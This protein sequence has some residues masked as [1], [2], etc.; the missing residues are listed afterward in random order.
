MLV[1]DGAMPGAACMRE[2][3]APITYPSSTDGAELVPGQL[4]SR[5]Y[6]K[7][8]AR[9]AGVP[10]TIAWSGLSPHQ[11][12]QSGDHRNTQPDR[13]LD[14]IHTYSQQFI[15]SVTNALVMAQPIF[16]SDRVSKSQV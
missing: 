12:N 9:D 10:I 4:A 6:E 7:P 8:A 3:M 2:V 16:L 15:D 13:Q 11:D 5:A 14:R 1:R